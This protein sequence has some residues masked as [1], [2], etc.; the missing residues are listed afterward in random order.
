[1]PYSGGDLKGG[2]GFCWNFI[3][4]VA[5]SASE[6]QAVTSKNTSSENFLQ[7][8]AI[9]ACAELQVEVASEAGPPTDR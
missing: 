9:A 6:I 2:T 4:M 3:I 5:I 1:L 7:V 8:A